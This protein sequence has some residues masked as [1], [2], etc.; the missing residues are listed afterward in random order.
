MNNTN[1]VNPNDYLVIQITILMF[2]VESLIS[3]HPNRAAVRQ[4][5]DQMYGQFQANTLAS[6]VA[7]PRHLDIAR[8]LVEKIFSL[9]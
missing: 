7:A 5:F 4:Q 9:P 6:G 2:A 3:T 1:D 8:Q